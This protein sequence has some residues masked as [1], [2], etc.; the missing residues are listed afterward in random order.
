ML[1]WLRKGD[2]DS[3]SSG[4]A[5]PSD[6]VHITL[7]FPR[8]IEVDDMRHVLY[9]Q[10]TGR[11]ICGN[12][13]VTAFR[14]KPFHHAIALVLAQPAVQRFRAIPVRHEGLG[15][16]VHLHPCPAEDHRAFRRLDVQHACQ[17]RH[18]VCA[19]HEIGHFPDFR[20]IIGGDRRP[21]NANDLGVAK[22]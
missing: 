8:H 20:C 22:M 21:F 12:Q 15:E 6:A 11:N 18:L 19:R 9:V 4:A 10:A 14:A 17:C 13:E 7:R 3:C 1:A 5:G 16:L 2:R